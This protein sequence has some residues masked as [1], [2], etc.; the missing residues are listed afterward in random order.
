MKN[1][2][3]SAKK[4]WVMSYEVK[5]HPIAGLTCHDDE[6]MTCLFFVPLHFVFL[7]IQINQARN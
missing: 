4:V 3:E 1:T 6:T 2:L 7:C 5:L